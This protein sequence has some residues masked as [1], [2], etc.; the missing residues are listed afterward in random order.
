MVRF[1]IGLGV[2]ALGLLIYCTVECIQTPRH[3]V[4]VLPKVSWIFIILLLPLLG[5]GL[6][7]AFGRAKDTPAA[8]Q[9]RGPAAPDDDPEFLRRVEIER[10]QHQRR[11]QETQKSAEQARKRREEA[12]RRDS[13]QSSEQSS[14][15][16]GA[17]AATGE[18]DSRSSEDPR[19]SDDDESE[20]GPDTGP[21]PQRG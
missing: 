2:V 4:R 21:T 13:Q 11:E 8:P 20:G 1:F 3:R 10:R 19:A 14:D 17:D 7:M 12:E 15:S 6:W 16:T 9:R 18:S 5:P